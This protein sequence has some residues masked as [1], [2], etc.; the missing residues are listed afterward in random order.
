L[1]Q[2][3]CVAL[4]DIAATFLH[5]GPACHSLDA[6]GH[7]LHIEFVPSRTHARTTRVMSRLLSLTYKQFVDFHL[8]E[9]HTGK[10][11]K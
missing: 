11:R 10:R 7:Y 1:D 8:V 5:S 3:L 2:A 9:R 4:T 6:F